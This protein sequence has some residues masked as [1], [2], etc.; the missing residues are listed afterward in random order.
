MTTTH[1]YT[2][3]QVITHDNVTE[4]LLKGSDICRALFYGIVYYVTR[5]IQIG[6]GFG[7][8]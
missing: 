6:V 2:G 1:S 3:D 5:T 4:S 7:S 8:T